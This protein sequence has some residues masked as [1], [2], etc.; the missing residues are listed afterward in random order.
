M[1]A[2]ISNPFESSIVKLDRRQKHTKSQSSSIFQGTLHIYSLD[3]DYQK[4]R[5]EGQMQK[6]IV[7]QS[8]RVRNTKQ[9]NQD[10]FGRGGSVL[11]RK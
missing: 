2:A 5:A 10:P 9:I 6:L 3:K 4:M 11:P 7:S 8:P 1:R